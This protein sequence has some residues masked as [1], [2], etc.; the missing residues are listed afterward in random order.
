M[1]GFC[2]L[3][4]VVAGLAACNS[5]SAYFRAAPVS[6]IAVDGSVFDVRVR[7]TLA[8]AIRVDSQYAPR[9]GPIRARAGLAM[10]LVSGCP[11]KRVLGDQAQ[12]TGKL[13][14][15]RPSRPSAREICRPLGQVQGRDGR[16]YPA[17]DCGLGRPG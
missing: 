7:G 9:F 12:A 10:E 15:P 4:L 6:R 16:R 17:Y 14:C 13:S 3:L 5:P 11:V 2:A 1:R 8:E